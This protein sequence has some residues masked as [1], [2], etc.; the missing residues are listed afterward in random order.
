PRLGVYADY[1]A[2][3]HVH[4]EDSDHTKGTR[5]EVLRAAKAAGVSIVMFTDHRGP[6]PDTWSGMREG[7]LF[8][9][10]SEDDHLLRFPDPTEST[11]EREPAAGRRPQHDTR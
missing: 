4:A 7:V 1:R 8:L 6:K 9:A 2:V 11:S 5:A 10:G 3:L